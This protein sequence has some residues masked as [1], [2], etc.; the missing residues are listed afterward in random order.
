MNER[1]RRVNRRIWYE[2]LAAG[3]LALSLASAILAAAGAA[4]Q[5]TLGGGASSLCAVAFLMPG[6]HF[7]VY[8]RCLMCRD[9]GIAPTAAFVP[10]REALRSQGLP[11]QLLV[12]VGH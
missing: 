9:P 4:L 5:Q 10:R 12:L 7:L 3:V 8:S 1:R 6:L 2:L 11:D